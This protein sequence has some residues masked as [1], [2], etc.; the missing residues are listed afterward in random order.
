MNYSGKLLR[1]WICL[2]AI[3]SAANGTVWGWGSTAHKIINKNAVIHLPPS[4]STLADRQAFLESHASDADN[5]KS[6]DTAEAP[7]HFIDLES[8][9]DFRHLPS[10]LA[11]LISRYGWTTVKEIGILP[12]ATM[13]TLD[14]LT[15]QMRR[16]NWTAAYLTA[17]DLGHYVGDAYQPLHCTVNYDGKLTGNDGIHSRYES[18]M[19][20]TYQSLLIITRDTVRYITDPYTFI[21]DYILRSNAY[22]DSILKAD[23]AAK[24]ASGWNGTG[25]AP[26]SYYT[27]LWGRTRSWTSALVQQSTVALASLWYTAWINATQS[28]PL[29]VG[30]SMGMP[31]RF[32]LEQNYPNPF[33]GSSRFGFSISAFS[34]VNLRVYDLLG[35]EVAV[36]VDEQKP[37]GVYEVRFDAG[38]LASGTY[39]YRLTAGH[40]AVSRKMSLMK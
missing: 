34:R 9:P 39:I 22:A 38:G 17:A 14:S 2:L 24:A 8:Y 40:Y 25:S 18:S 28:I 31:E 29:A 3:F 12:W 35:R 36:L 21:L 16:G 32:A 26:Q 4:M 33:N 27:A 10:S 19:I 7:K 30:P 11:V 15:A 13:W 20:N 23:N 6:A 1:F 5:R 37:A